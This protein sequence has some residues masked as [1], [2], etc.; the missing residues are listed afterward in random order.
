M[1]DRQQWIE[2]AWASL[3]RLDPLPLLREMVATPSPTGEERPLAEYL[4]AHLA[5]GGLAGRCQIIDDRQANAVGRLAGAGGGPDLLLYAPIDTIFSEEDSPWLG[6]EMPPDMALEARVEG[7]ELIGRGA[8]NP[9]GYA[10]AAVLAAEAVARARVPLRGDLVVGLGA[11]GMPTDRAPS[12]DHT[13]ANAGQGSGCAF[14][15]GQG[16]R[17][18]YAIICKPG[19]SVSWEE[20]GL[21]WF[22]IEVGGEL[23]YTG[24]RHL[25]PYR[26]PIL[27]AAETMAAIEAWFPEYTAGNRS[28]LVAPQGSIGAVEGGWPHKPAFVPACCRFYVDLRV[29]PRTDPMEVKH[30]L[31]QALDRIRRARPETP[32]AC[33][34][35]LAIP[36]SHT[37][38]GN[39]IVQ[40]CIRAW[41]AVAQAEHQPRTDTSGATDANILRSWGIPTAR[42]GMP[43]ERASAFSMDRASLSGI[44]QL[45]RC[46]VAVAVETCTRRRDEVGLDR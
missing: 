44:R 36:G 5:A 15:L 4:A 8:E 19:W 12:S 40:A 6:P 28:G 18:D 35:V 38:P 29:S 11:G 13:R 7:D 43:R 22:R 27:A 41:E 25:L 20:V 42:I 24:I 2:A 32:L 34:M 45:A 33:E 30:Q 39:W 9:K 14:M 31:Q 21:A 16:V 23:N 1:D 3:E 46:L 26:N 37:D 17:G 10:A